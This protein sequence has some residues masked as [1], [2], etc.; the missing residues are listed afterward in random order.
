[1]FLLSIL[2][3]SCFE[4]NLNGEY[5]EDPTDNDYY[6]AIIW[7]VW[8]G[9]YSLKTSRMMIRSKTFHDA[10]NFDPNNS[11]N[12]EIPRLRNL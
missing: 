12:N 5:H 10:I 9:D 4:C 1:M 6:H 2:R 11:M 7:E 3:F 8:R